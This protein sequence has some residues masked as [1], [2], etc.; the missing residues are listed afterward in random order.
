MHLDEVPLQAICTWRTVGLVVVIAAAIRGA[1]GLSAADSPA[2]GLLASC[3]VFQLRASIT[4]ATTYILP[5]P[6]AREV[7]IEPLREE[8]SIQAS[9]KINP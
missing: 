2:V 9:R 1:G 4:R 7:F 6:K 5:D 3:F 8:S